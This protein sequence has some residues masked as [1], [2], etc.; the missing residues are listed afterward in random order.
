MTDTNTDTNLETKSY[1][2]KCGITVTQEIL[3]VDQDNSL[4]LLLSSLGLETFAFDDIKTLEFSR[5]TNAV[6]E[7]FKKKG[8]SEFLKIIL[9]PAEGVSQ[10]EFESKVGKI[11][12]NELKEIIS[13]FFI[14]NPELITAF[15]AIAKNLISMIQTAILQFTAMKSKTI[16]TTS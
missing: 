16:S 5:I 13:D 6:K 10:Q 7:I 2:L 1:N 12:N 8:L 4:G 14:L 11:K 15:S 9:I 3:N